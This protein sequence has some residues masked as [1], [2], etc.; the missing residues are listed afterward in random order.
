MPSY[1][2]RRT[3]ATRTQVTPCWLHE[4][5][6]KSALGDME[7]LEV[8][9]NDRWAGLAPFGKIGFHSAGA[10]EIRAEL[11]WAGEVERLISE[12]HALVSRPQ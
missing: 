4:D 6:A 11:F 1:L 8:V 5:D 9:S 2:Q 3:G 7:N 10:R 12:F